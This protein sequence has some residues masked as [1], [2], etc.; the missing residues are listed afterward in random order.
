MNIKLPLAIL[1]L[2][3]VQASTLSGQ[4]RFAVS[5]EGGPSYTYI[6]GSQDNSDFLKPILGG[7]GGVAFQYNFL[8][9]LAFKTGIAYERKGADL[10]VNSIMLNYTFHFDYLTIPM[11][12]KGSF[13]KKVRFLVSAGP[14][15][16][17]LIHQT[18]IN[19]HYYPYNFDYPIPDPSSY[20]NA[21]KFDFGVIASIG[22][23]VRIKHQYALSMEVS[24]HYGLVNTGLFPSF[25]SESGMQYN[26]DHDAINNA[27]ILSLG[28]SYFFPS[29]NMN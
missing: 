10:L 15:V 20:E 27:V 9:K 25:L 22:I 18:Y 23:E 3:G 2:F 14:Y 1:I 26:F 21:N 5:I 6:H 4:Q 19:N 28:F 13:G 17:Y 12:I 7:Y 8:D 11:L 29:G 24:D 16:S